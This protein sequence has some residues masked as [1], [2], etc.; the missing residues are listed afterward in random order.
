MQNPD[1]MEHFTNYENILK[2]CSSG[3]HIPLISTEAATKVLK[4]MKSHVIDIYSIT[5][6]H[7]SNAGDKGIEHFKA[8]LNCVISDVNNATLEELNMALGV[9]LYKGHRKDKNSDRSYRNIS[10]CPFT[11]KAV[12]LYLRDL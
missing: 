12:D 11:A 1:L 8:L 3:C 6:K 10:T 2:I 4:R 7:Y 9:I 5:A